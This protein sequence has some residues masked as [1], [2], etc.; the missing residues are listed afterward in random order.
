MKKSSLKNCQILICVGSG[1]VGKTTLA[2]SLGVAAA[3][4]G[5]NT[6]VLTIDPS[7]R[8]AQALGIE[9]Q[10]ENTLVP[11]QSYPGNLKAAI[12]DHITVFND[13][14][15]RASQKEETVRRILKNKLYQQLTT[16]L[17]GSQEFTALEKL[18]QAHESKEFDLIILDTPPAQH[19]IEFLQAPQKL[20]ALFNEGVASWFRDPKDQEGGMF[21]KLLST[22]TRR[23][24]K[25]LEILTG[26]EFIRELADFF[27]LVESWQSK[28][29]K[30]TGQ[31]HQLLVSSETHFVLVTN[32]EEAKLKEA[33]IFSR[34]INKSGYHLQH[35]FLNK[36][37][38]EWSF[39]EKITFAENS[40]VSAEVERLRAIWKTYYDNKSQLFQ[41]FQAQLPAN[42][43]VHRIA[44]F[45]QPV[46]Q[47]KGLEY[48]SDQIM[49]S[50]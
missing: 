34:E 40:K 36:A 50:Q 43:Q 5:L 14:V 7:Q 37:F 28:L 45:I 23:V 9:N 13:F 21:R 26:A 10:K 15:K 6:L 38:P 39:D 47:L 17:S 32:F 8:L 24:L 33:E 20:A 42:T 41:N 25:A 44:D 29:Y 22:G 49:E 3:R 2:A 11:G 27:S 19:A 46:S 30:R 48:L 4:E 18:Y 16:T 12:V 1:G 31:F 35:I